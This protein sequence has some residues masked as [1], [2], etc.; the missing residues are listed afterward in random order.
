[1]PLRLTRLPTALRHQF[2]TF[3]AQPLDEELLFPLGQPIP[4]GSQRSLPGRLR[5]TITYP[6]TAHADD[7]NPIVVTDA[8]N[9]CAKQLGLEAPGTRP[10]DTPFQREYPLVKQ[11][12]RILTA[13]FPIQNTR[14]IQGLRSLASG[15]SSA[16]HFDI[17]N[18]SNKPLGATSG[19][20]SVC[21]SLWLLNSAAAPAESPTNT[22]SPGEV[23]VCV[24]VCLSRGCH[25]ALLHFC[26]CCREEGS[27]V[28]LRIVGA[29][30]TNVA[31]ANSSR[32]S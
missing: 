23:L 18:V 19:R 16:V 30:L 12:N 27:A 15:E 11:T 7:F 28:F 17:F 10:R 5:Y 21:V 25:V 6:N 8:L 26:T 4:A 22:G 31:L 32:V 13:Q 2:K 20:R 14:G 9:V 24:C 1:M 3:W 29:R